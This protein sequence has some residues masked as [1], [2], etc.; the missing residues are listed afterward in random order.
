YHYSS[1][2]PSAPRVEARPDLEPARAASALVWALMRQALRQS[3][4]FEQGTFVVHG[5]GVEQ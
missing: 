2:L 1:A 4:G 3:K 5:S